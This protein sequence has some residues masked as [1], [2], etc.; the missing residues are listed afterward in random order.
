MTDAPTYSAARHAAATPAPKLADMAEAI[1]FIAHEKACSQRALVDGA[2]RAT[3]DPE[4]MRRIACLE[5]AMA[6]LLRIRANVLTWPKEI[7]NVI[8]PPVQEP[9]KR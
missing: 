8:A 2:F 3:Y 4:S 7:Q 6:L 5:D 1:D 9:K